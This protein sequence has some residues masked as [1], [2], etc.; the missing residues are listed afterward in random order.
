MFAILGIACIALISSCKKDSISGKTAAVPQDDPKIAVLKKMGF[1]TDGIIDK[2]KYFI[3]ENDIM[4]SKDADIFSKPLTASGKPDFFRGPKTDQSRQDYTVTQSSVT[5]RI[6]SS[7]P[8]DGSTD[9]WHSAI[10]TAV[11]YWNAVPNNRIVFSIT[12]SS[13]ADIVIMSDSNL[14]PD[15]AIAASEFPSTSD[16]PGNLMLI[17]LDYN[18]NE[19]VAAGQK[20]YNIVHELGHT[21]GYR[22]TNWDALGEP[23][24]STSTLGPYTFNIYGAN[25]VN[26]TRSGTSDTHSVMNG[27]TAEDSWNGFSNFDILAQRTVYALDATQIPIYRYSSTSRHF[28]TSSWS[29]LGLGG[30]GFTYEGPSGYLYNYSKTGT[31]PFYRL[32]NSTTS[33]HLYQTSSSIPVGYH[34]ESIMGYVYTTQV[35]GTVPLYRYYKASG[36]HFY[37]LDINELGGGTNQGYTYEGIA[38]YVVK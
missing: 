32:Y 17:N 6:D 5:I 15:Y 31:V 9:D 27:G 8:S 18:S 29:E 26:G 33:D 28:Y 11:G 35:T 36:G 24:Y 2:G 13:S 22:H 19:T 16:L 3:V 25:L 20:A 14:L 1:Q 37:T 4:I 21:I 12:T 34:Y 30:A 10:A 38:C 23:T 7:I